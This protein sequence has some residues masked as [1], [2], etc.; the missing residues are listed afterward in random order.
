MVWPMT[1]ARVG[2]PSTLTRRP[3]SE[4]SLAA[5]VLSSRRSTGSRLVLQDR[6]VRGE[7]EPPRVPVE[8]QA[9]AVLGLRGGSWR[10]PERLR[11]GAMRRGGGGVGERG[12]RQCQDRQ[13]EDRDEGQSASVDVHAATVAGTDRSRAAVPELPVQPVGEPTTRGL[14]LESLS[15]LR[16]LPTDVRAVAR[17]SGPSWSRIKAVGGHRPVLTW[18]FVPLKGT[19]GTQ[20]GW[21]GRRYPG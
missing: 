11:S 18:L 19:I 14:R 4:P 10:R 13:G 9:R 17:H 12:A 2:R 21:V 16:P 7:P 1:L 3:S 6:D 5:T 15:R 20:S 8:V